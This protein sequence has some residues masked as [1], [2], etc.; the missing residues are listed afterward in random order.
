MARYAVVQQGIVVTI[1]EA[2]A[3]V[4]AA[5]GWRPAGEAQIGWRLIA[6]ELV[7]PTPEVATLRA[8]RLADLAALRFTQE[9]AGLTVNGARIET[10]RAAQSL[11][12]GAVALLGLDPGRVIDWKTAVGTWVSLDAPTVQALALAVATHVE[13]CFSA[14]RAHAEALA[15]LETAEDLTAYDL[16]VGWPEG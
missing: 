6:G 10:D 3:A 12:T 4:A 13:A 14:E 7:A 15:A 5:Q 16:T 11:L 2:D 8:Q 1:A 9:T